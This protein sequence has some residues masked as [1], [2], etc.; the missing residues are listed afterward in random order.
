[1]NLGVDKGSKFTKTAGG[2]ML[3][4]IVRELAADELD[5]RQVDKY[6]TKV[7]LNNVGYVFGDTG[8]FAADLSKS[9][10]QATKL[11]VQA[12]IVESN[13]KQG[14][15]VNLVVG[16]PIAQYTRQK[17]AMV[18]LIRSE[19][20]ITYNKNGEQRNF[21]IPNVTVFPEAAGAFY[22]QD[23]ELYAD[24][25]VLVLDIGGLSVDTALFVNKNLTEYETHED[26]TLKLF[27]KLSSEVNRREG[28][29][30]TAW[31]VYDILVKKSYMIRGVRTPADYLNRYL[32]EHVNKIVRDLK[33]EYDMISLD[34]M[35]VVGGGGSLLFDRIKA[36]IPQSKLAT[37]P[38]SANARGFQA[39]AES[40]YARI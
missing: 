1:M 8:E 36:Q 26:G 35:L 5:I 15:A 18:E 21:T 10:H 29:R 37:D 22:A 6:G 2:V 16:L 23:T 30:F 31:D 38:L 20:P 17:D 4:S 3:R 12:A 28:T 34:E 13:P 27:Q 24:K 32:D 9:T 40:T 25:S 11:L 33:N 14:E 19:M 7:S 39:I